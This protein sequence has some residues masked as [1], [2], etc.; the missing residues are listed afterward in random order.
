MPPC[1]CAI[2]DPFHK[3]HSFIQLIFLFY[4]SSPSKKKLRTQTHIIHLIRYIKTLWVMTVM[5]HISF[6]P[7][8]NLDRLFSERESIVIVFNTSFFL[9]CFLRIWGKTDENLQITLKWVVLALA[10]WKKN[11][12]SRAVLT[13]LLLWT[14]SLNNPSFSKMI[15]LFENAFV[16][17]FLQASPH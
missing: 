12:N 15:V 2:N 7:I 11:I 17:N 4:L 9:L 10:L 13:Y 5:M 3:Q 6:L 14:E 8:K 16:F 1:Y